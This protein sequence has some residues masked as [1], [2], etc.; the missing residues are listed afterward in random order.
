[1]AETAHQSPSSASRTPG[2]HPAEVGR[3]SSRRSFC[4]PR[5]QQ[6]KKKE[7]AKRRLHSTSLCG[8]GQMDTL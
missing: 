7:D 6:K 4:S 5:M 2:A 3:H 8:G 1:M